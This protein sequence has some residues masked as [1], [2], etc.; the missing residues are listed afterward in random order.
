MA[1]DAIELDENQTE[2]RLINFINNFMNNSEFKSRLEGDIYGNTALKHIFI[3]YDEEILKNHYKE[4][5]TLEA[6]KRINASIPTIEHIFSQE[7]R[8]DFPSRGFNST[9]EYINKINK[10]GNLTLLEKSINS[11][12]QNETTEQKVEKENLYKKSIFQITKKVT[13]EIKNR[14]NSFLCNHIDERTKE[15]SEFCPRR[16][17]I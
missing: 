2:S 17:Q 15:L 7:P 12:C 10:L 1:R 6:L 5:Y 4:P 14:G 13:A 9:E 16:W 11:A 8:F 3:E